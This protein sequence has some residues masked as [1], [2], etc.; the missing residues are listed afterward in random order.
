MLDAFLAYQ[1]EFDGHD[2]QRYFAS[3]PLLP[4][5]VVVAY[6]LAVRFLPRWMAH[7]PPYEL[8]AASRVWNVAIA[9][10][11]V[12][13]A[14]V[15]VPHLLRQLM[16]HGLWYTVCADVYELAGYGPPAL[17]A[18]LFT[19]SKLLELVDTLL[20]ILRKRPLI[21]LHWFHHASV[22]GFAWAAWVYETPAALWYGAMNYSV[23]AVMYSYFALTSTQRCRRAVLRVAPAIT[24]LQ[25]SQFAWGSVIN[26]FAA[27]AYASPT[28]GCAIRLPILYLGASLYVVYGA[29]FVQLFVSRY[30]RKR[31]PL[32][33]AHSLLPPHARIARHE[34]DAREHSKTAGSRRHANGHGG[35][36]CGGASSAWPENG[37]HGHSAEAH[38]A[39]KAV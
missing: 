18:S 20:I 23:H 16:R 21:T 13:G 25:I 1:R 14:S 11:S 7:R 10:F 31:A 37:D 34:G 17:W 4:T 22:I 15:C 3:H 33:D 19:W 5:T 24:A 9:V 27:V 8:R 28:I 6:L 32:P 26:I 38:S 30:L 12:C 35:I 29:L 39:L 36:T 2:A